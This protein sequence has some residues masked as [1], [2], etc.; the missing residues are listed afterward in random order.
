MKEFGH[1]IDGAF[2]PPS[3]KMIDSID[4]ASGNKWCRIS[5]GGA[6]EADLAM[7]S[8]AKAFEHGPWGETTANARADCIEQLADTLQADWET[9]VEA[10]VSDNGKRI[11]EVRAQFAGLHHWF[12]AFSAQARALGPEPQNNAVPGVSSETTWLPFGPVV[13]ITPWNSPLMILAWKLAPA[14]AAGNVMVVKPSEMAS[15]STMMFADLL[16]RAGLP[17][18]VLNV[19]TGYGPEIGEALVRHPKTRMVTFTGSDAGGSKVAEAA[20]VNVVPVTLELGGKSPQ[21]V[22]ADADIPSAVNGIL[23]GIFASNGQSCVAG[24]RLIV[25][26]QIKD[27]LL[28]ALIKR[29]STLKPGD[30]RE[31]MTEIGPLANEPHFDKVSAMIAETQQSGATCLLD[32]RDISKARDGFYIG[33]TIFDG[34]TPD[35][36]IWCEE[37]FGP[38]LSVAAFSTEDEAVE[39]ANSTDY[40]LAAGV[41]TADDQKGGRIARRIRA[42][43]VYINHYRSV[44]PGA[45]IGGLCRSGYGREL[46]PDAVKHFLQSRSIWTGNSAFPDPFPSNSPEVQ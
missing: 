40:G 11:V 20:A 3:E 43:T 30:P 38:V 6:R 9:L 37:V 24:S 23:A 17:K 27:Q 45:P 22:F 35:M 42:G 25:E 15:V 41:W 14:L 39:L 19:V 7:Q 16:C 31:E 29:A 1:F 26:E 13:A 5:A 2:T 32:G 4:P 18:G 33:P 8:A 10:E 34:V 21:V 28:D 44:D 36:R 12:R 46:G